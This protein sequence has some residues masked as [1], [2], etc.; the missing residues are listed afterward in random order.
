M[1]QKKN[2]FALQTVLVVLSVFL[3]L[4][5]NEWRQSYND[6]KAARHALESIQ[7]ELLRNRASV[8]TALDYHTTLI[9]TLNQIQRDPNPARP[10]IQVFRKGYFAPATLLATSWQ[11]ARSTDAVSNMKYSDVL[12]LSAI[13]EEG[14]R[15]N[16]QSQQT[17]EIVYRTLF[18]VGHEGLL[19]NYANLTTILSSFQFTEC[20]LLDNYNATLS[21]ISVPADTLALPRLCSFMLRAVER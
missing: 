18:E 19:N 11:A 12:A 14:E 17:G 4:A 9:D 1:N 16:E 15:Y 8:V 7:D 10:S 13:Y 5:V 2:E 6:K 20:S 3:A 21:T